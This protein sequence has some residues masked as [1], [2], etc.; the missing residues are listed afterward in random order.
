MIFAGGLNI[1]TRFS[2]WDGL[3]ALKSSRS[4]D[5]NSGEAPGEEASASISNLWDFGTENRWYSENIIFTI[6]PPELGFLGL[7]E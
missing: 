4:W 5:L 1:N 7:I 3:G 2:Y 6:H